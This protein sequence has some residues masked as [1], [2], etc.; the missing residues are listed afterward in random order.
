MGFIGVDDPTQKID[1]ITL[2]RTAAD[3]MMIEMEKNRMA[4]E[5]ERALREAKEANN[6]KSLFLFNMSHDIRTP[7]NAIT[8]FIRIAMENAKE[9]K[10]IDALKKADLS[11]RHML[12]ILNDVLDMSRIESGKMEFRHQ[13][14][15]PSE[16]IKNIEAMYRQSI[17]EK[18]IQF[19]VEY[20]NLPQM[21]LTDETRISQVIGNLL[22]NA[23]KFTPKGG[24]ILF[25]TECTGIDKDGKYCFI[26]YVK[27]T[28]I[29]M[30]KEFLNKVFDPFERERSATVSGTQGTGIGL[31]LAKRIAGAMEGDLTVTSIQGYGSEFIFTFKAEQVEQVEGNTK[32][33][34]KEKIVDFRG[35]R[36]LLVEDIDLNREIAVEILSCEGFLIEEAENGAIAVEMIEK[37]EPNYYDCVLM[38]IQ[39]PIMNGY[40]A[41][42]KI[43]ALENPELAN[44]PII[45]MTANA[46][47]EDCKQAFEAGMN[48]HVAKPIDV[49]NL[50]QVLSD[51][52]N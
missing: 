21:V 49:Q 5:R 13:N 19:Y 47:A 1:D 3:I 7:M 52:L 10:V 2:L 15:V 48:R 31:S 20:Q 12:S 17:E 43:R 28:G 25:Q 39:M 41:T 24:K 4:M 14:I 8:G 50:L 36:V 22:S 33:L 16:H 35:K 29:G 18:G 44:I 37:S 45:A 11:S 51:V 30:S 26:V 9:P 42:K 34:L 6:A 46:F 27:D 38:D 23:T 32:A 40:E